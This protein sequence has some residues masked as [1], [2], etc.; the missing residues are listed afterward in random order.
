MGSFVAGFVGRQIDND[1]K[2]VASRTKKKKLGSCVV[3]LGAPFP[4]ST[5]IPL[6]RERFMKIV[7]YFIR[8]TKLKYVK[9]FTH[10][11][12]FI[13]SFFLQNENGTDVDKEPMVQ[14]A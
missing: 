9:K 7:N 2:S 11:L 5:P 10:C 14:S 1:K 6:L 13:F 4:P 12:L 3:G 8:T